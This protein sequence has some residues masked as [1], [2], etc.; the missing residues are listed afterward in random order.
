MPKKPKNHRRCLSCHKIAP[1]TEF[2]RVVRVYPSRDV[3][4]DWG[5]GR[6][7]YLCPNAD[8][9]KSAARKNRMGK[10][11]KANIPDPIYQILGA[12]LSPLQG[13]DNSEPSE[14]IG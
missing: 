4:L 9:L 12:R 7:V 1:K 10:A 3:E 14:T 2:W 8:C 5:S 11:L 13:T 6:S